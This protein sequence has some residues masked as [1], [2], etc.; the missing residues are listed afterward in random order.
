MRTLPL[1]S[2]PLR[3]SDAPFRII[4]DTGSRWRPAAFALEA[5]IFGARYGV[6]YPAHVAEF[7]PYEDNSVF[8]IV[9]DA[10]DEVAGVMRWIVP[11]PAGLKTLNEAAQAP[12]HLD[13]IRAAE[14]AGVD[15]ARTWDLAS[16]AVRPRLGRHRAVVTAALYHA[17]ALAVA[18]NRVR[19]LLMTVDERVRTVLE[20]HGFYG[21]ALP[22]A[23]PM[24][25]C[26]S[27]ASTP[28]FGHCAEMRRLQQRL[29]PE[30]FRLITL[31]TGLDVEVPH[32]SA[33]RLPGTG[34]D[35]PA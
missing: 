31:G 32:R 3:S 4:V 2:A 28:V 21:R 24:P 18:E 19:S 6:P 8:A 1:A 14:A 35:R 11:G 5:Q 17:V 34:P 25:F 15:P 13:S 20:A 10:E 30:A 27:P 7:A 26:G 16:L 12:W 29:N 23:V 33:F 9:A 22:G